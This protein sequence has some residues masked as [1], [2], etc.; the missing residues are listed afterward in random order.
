MN[1]V[2]DNCYGLYNISNAELSILNDVTI[3]GMAPARIHRYCYN[4]PTISIG[5]FSFAVIFYM[6]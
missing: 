2:H 3:Y 5:L 4:I 1:G 6:S